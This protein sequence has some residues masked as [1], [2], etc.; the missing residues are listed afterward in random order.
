MLLDLCIWGYRHALPSLIQIVVFT[1]VSVL[2]IFIALKNNLWYLIW[3]SFLLCSHVAN[4]KYI[5]GFEHKG[6][7]NTWQLQHTHLPVW[8]Q[9]TD[10]KR[11][12]CRFPPP[13]CMKKPEACISE[14]WSCGTTPQQFKCWIGAVL[15]AHGGPTS[16]GVMAAVSKRLSKHCIQN[17]MWWFTYQ[18][19]RQILDH[20][21][22]GTPPLP[23]VSC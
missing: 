2:V 4:V 5:Q 21:T 18:S 3:I 20:Q 12:H 23:P 19:L 11:V 16:S 9:I 6:N 7:R 17:A 13:S 14:A 1:S 10:K 22:L 8:S 15:P